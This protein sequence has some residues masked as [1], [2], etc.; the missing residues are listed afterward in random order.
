VLISVPQALGEPSL[1]FEILRDGDTLRLTE[2]VSAVMHG[3]PDEAVASRTQPR[4]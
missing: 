1:D 2:P 3:Q 4:E